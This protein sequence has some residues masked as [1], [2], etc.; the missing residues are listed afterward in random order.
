MTPGVCVFLRSFYRLQLKLC[1]FS[2]IFTI[3][4]L[5][6]ACKMWK[7]TALTWEISS[8]KLVEKFHISAFLVYYSLYNWIG[9]HE[10]L[11]LKKYICFEPRKEETKTST[12]RHEWNGMIKWTIWYFQQCACVNAIY[13]EPVVTTMYR[14]KNNE[15]STRCLS[16]E[17]SVLARAR[18]QLLN[19]L[20]ISTHLAYHMEK[21]S[22]RLFYI[23]RNWY[24]D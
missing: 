5:D 12:K 22:R 6:M 4:R 20:H 16:L 24:Y 7:I 14:M 18:A 21:I 11:K 1:L 13:F 19:M 3:L 2:S 15:S 8:W 23:C 9:E 10:I 17:M